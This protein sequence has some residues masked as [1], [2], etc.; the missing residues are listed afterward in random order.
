MKVISYVFYKS[1]AKS[2]LIVR[3]SLTIDAGRIK[4]QTKDRDRHLL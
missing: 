1:R 2:F 3:F 4:E